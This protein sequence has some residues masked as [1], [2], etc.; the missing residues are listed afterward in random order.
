[1]DRLIIGLISNNN[2]MVPTAPTSLVSLAITVVPV[3]RTQL[4][5]IAMP[6]DAN[7][8]AGRGLSILYQK[9]R[10][11]LHNGLMQRSS[12]VKQVTGSN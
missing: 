11:L 8:C 2:L 1:M 5:V 12:T 3:M 4:T 7:S 6:M 10:L 9:Q